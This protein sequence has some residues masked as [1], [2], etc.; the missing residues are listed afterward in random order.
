MKIIRSEH[1]GMCFG[2]RDAIALAEQQARQ[3]PVTILGELVHNPTVLDHLRGHGIRIEPDLEHVE[4]ETVMITAHGVSERRR[5]EVASRNLRVVESTCPLVHVAH[6]AVAGLVAA[7]YHPVI[8]GRR[9]HVEVRGMTEDLEEFD[10]ILEDTDVARVRERPRFGVAA[11]TT[12]PVERVRH[13]VSLLRAR[14]PGSDLR[15]VDTVC[16]PTKQRQHAAV[17]LAQRCDVVI[18]IGGANSNNTRELVQTCLRHCAH[19]HQV[20]HAA[21]INPEWIREAALVGITAGTSTPDETIRAIEQRLYAL[22][23]ASPPALEEDS[24]EV[25]KSAVASR[26]PGER[27]SELH[28]ATQGRR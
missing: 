16:Q 2:V 17:E 1:L 25:A 3:G 13:L 20:Q 26:Q 9:D 15:F 22:A 18:V 27:I 12:Q 21:Q 19:V 4:T 5:R 6:R 23:A 24:H 10:V 14:F 28:E 8:V 11:Q 7:G